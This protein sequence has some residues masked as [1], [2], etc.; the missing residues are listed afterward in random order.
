MRIG[1]DARL[2]KLR[3]GIGNYVRNLLF[4]YASSDT[5]HTFYL[6]LDEKSVLEGIPDDPRFTA[7]LIEQP[8]YALWEQ[9]ILPKAARLDDLDVIHFP[10]NTAPLLPVGIPSVLTLHDTI[11]FHQ[12]S[13]QSLYYRLIAPP[14]ARHSRIV[15]T[16]SEFSKRDI[17]TRMPG[18]T[19]PILVIHSGPG[20]TL[21]GDDRAG[22]RFSQV[23]SVE[24][25]FALALGARDPRKNMDVVL[26]AF[27][28][29]ARDGPPPL[30]LVIA[31]LDEK[32]MMRT[33]RLAAETRIG[34]WVRL[35]PFVEDAV[36]SNLYADATMFV[37]PSLYEG[38]GFP[39]LEAMSRGT[40]V[41]AAERTATPEIAGDAAVY[42]DGYD[43]VAL[44]ECISLIMAS[45]ELRVN[46]A[47]LGKTRAAMFSWRA[48]AQATLEAYEVA[49][50][51]PKG[52]DPR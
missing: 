33:E 2:L 1:I 22:R 15:I 19:A 35:M 10:G 37:F 39:L 8:N 49:A 21:A 44:A 11:F 17:L 23:L 27:A 20:S 28:V 43:E 16:V 6:Y 42:F 46:L 14:A 31:G 13:W 25:P 36:L 5:R 45:S 34:D 52:L 32:T 48:A 47:S 38:F 51:S 40:P 7:R 29:L 50:S 9:A 12:R 3:R 30:D 24:R 26:R 4:E 18:L 41:V